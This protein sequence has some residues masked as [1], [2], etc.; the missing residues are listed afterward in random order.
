MTLSNAF[1]EAVN[2]GS[3][4]RVRIMMK[5]S[6]LVDPTFKE[7]KEMENITN[8]ILGLYDG[9]DG[10]E[11]ITDETEWDDNYMDKLMVQ[12]V[13]NFSHERIRHLKDVVH[14]LR[15]IPIATQ[16]SPLSESKRT[17]YSSKNAYYSYEEQKRRDQQ[18]G[19]YNCA[20]IATGAVAG[21]IVGGVVASAVGVTVMG[22]TVAGAIVGG[23][24]MSVA[25]N[26]GH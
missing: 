16:G 4:R 12:V 11:F 26:G 20:K 5:D 21:A 25:M 14:H 1:F 17:D 19:R 9:H 8:S 18:D 7:F 15:P 10:R 13:S 22:G 2:S 23:V 3:M 6:L 24:V